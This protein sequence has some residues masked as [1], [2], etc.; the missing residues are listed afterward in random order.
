VAS[1]FT[2]SL[3]TSPF[4]LHGHPNVVD[5]SVRRL[6]QA[7]TNEDPPVQR[8]P[9]IT[10]RHLRYIH[11]YA[12]QT[13]SDIVRAIADLISAAFFFACR[14]CEYLEVSVRGKT[15]LLTINDITFSSKSCQ[16]ITDLSPSNLHQV[17]FVSLTFRDQKNNE[18]NVT[19]TQQRTLDSILCPVRL[20]SRIVNRI[21]SDPN[22][23]QQS[24]V[25]HFLDAKSP[26]SQR[27][28]RISQQSVNYIL[29]LTCKLKPPLHFGY[30]PSLIGTH[31]IRSGAA[32]A[33][34]LADEHPHKIMLLGR[35]SSDAFLVYLRPQVQE[36]TSGMSSLM[37]QTEDFH[38]A[39]SQQLQNNR[40]H[41]IDPLIRHDT[42]SLLGSRSHSNNGPKSLAMSFSK[43][44]LFH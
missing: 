2:S 17:H 33:L 4:H 31:S 37:L 9:A 34:F 3:R 11:L 30:P 38:T 27:T 39:N 28:K 23:S 24:P 12:E 15:K 21:L 40:H 19:R 36:W 41:P 13:N 26:L 35:W 16:P 22:S 8:S 6:L 10:P 25:C 7:W 14:S 43:F 29:R 32:M 1:K 5:P 18:K 20:W 42:R 44:H